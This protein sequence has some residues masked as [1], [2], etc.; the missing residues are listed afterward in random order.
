MSRTRKYGGIAVL[1]VVILIALQVGLSFLVRTARMRA[2]LIARLETAF[3]RPVQVGELSFQ[4]LPMPELEMDYV[5]I[6]EDPAFGH[7]YFLRAERMNA[8]LRWT[9]LLRGHLQLGTIS[10]TRPS[11]IL[12][13]NSAGRW[14]LEG[15]LPPARSSGNSSS[16]VGPQRPPETHRLQ[17]IEFDDGRIN[18][19]MGDEKRPFAF[20]NVSGRVEQLSP[21]RWRLRL[22]AEPW[23]SGVPLQSA[24]TLYVVGDVAGTS[25]RLQPA[26]VQVHWEKVSLADLFRLATGN[27]S[28]VRGEFALDGNASVGMTPGSDTVA[29]DWGFQLQARATQVHRWDLIERNDNPKVNVTLKGVWNPAKD[30]ARADELRVEMAHSNLNGSAMLQTASPEAWHAKFESMAVQGEDLLAWLRAFRPGIDEQVAVDDFLSG[31]LSVGGWPLRLEDAGIESKGGML[32]IPGLK[33]SHIDAFRGTAKN[34]K[35]SLAGLHVRLGAD[36]STPTLK[37]RLPAAPEESLELN[38][39]Q[40]SLTRLGSLKV[41]LRLA[42]A[43]RLFKLTSALGRRLEQGWEYNGPISGFVAWNWSGDWR[44]LHRSGSVDLTK[45]RLAIVGL[46]QPLKIDDARLEWKDGRRSATIGKMEGFGA[47]WSGAVSET[48]AIDAAAQNNWT[49]QLHADRLDAA[50]LDRW[51]GPRARPNWVQRLMTSL[52]GETASN[53]KA[54]EL[55]RR[56]SAEGEMTA[57]TV[58][59]EKIKLAQAHAKMQFRNLQL[60]VTSA[61]A[62]WAGGNVQGQVTAAFSP[63][64]HYEVT[65]E[66]ERAN[67]AQLPWSPRWAERWSGTASG[68]VQLSTGGVGRDELLRQLS[69]EGS[70]KLSKIELRGWDVRASAESGVAR[71]GTSRWTSGEGKFAIGERQVRFEAIQLDGPQA[72]TQLSGTLGFDMSGQVTFLPGPPAK[73]GAKV[74]QASRGLSLSGPL[75]TPKA[76]VQAVAEET[77]RP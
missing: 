3:G 40:D 25:S 42:D 62:Q 33:E 77:S 12:V 13:R 5:T 8:G 21:G 4:L 1:L 68:S 44:D 66:V 37:T 36:A 29:N 47:N 57:D 67:L 46:N 64:P 27:D 23:R 35:F 61:D 15:W 28:G 9:G 10:L 48:V 24:G 38:L 71:A 76:V 49:F 31:N 19:K 74:V 11:L 16:P 45:S 51:F 17:T 7:E 55:L 6:G 65:A 14:N 32:A 39:S 75:E 70:V 52:L 50:E 72:Q 41:N 30:E 56:V 34:G 20:I 73:R 63:V 22:Q 2:F 43:S 54:S 18:F 69:G 26:Q 58:S 59:I 53:G 60:Q